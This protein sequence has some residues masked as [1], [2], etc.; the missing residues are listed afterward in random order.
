MRKG[1]LAV[2]DSLENGVMC[3]ITSECSPALCKLYGGAR[4]FPAADGRQGIHK[5]IVMEVLSQRY[6]GILGMVRTSEQ[7]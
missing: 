6:S 4:Y 7:Q 3:S 5:K 2:C 1:Y